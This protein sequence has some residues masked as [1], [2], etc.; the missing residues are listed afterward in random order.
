MITLTNGELLQAMDGLREL[1]KLELPVA[2]A[3]RVRKVI[4]AVDAHLAD[5]NDTRRSLIER[6]A[7]RGD[8]G[9]VKIGAGGQVTFEGEG[10]ATFTAEY[11]ELLGLTWEH[12]YGIRVSDLGTKIELAPQ[13]L[14]SLGNLLEEPE[15][16]AEAKSDAQ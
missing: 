3:L 9:Q 13:V 11:T 12:P 10:A 16:A 1:T 8:D 4:R 15:E 2:G 7:V 5:I 6:Y 14:L